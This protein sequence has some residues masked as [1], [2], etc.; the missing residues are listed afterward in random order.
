MVDM[1][2]GFACSRFIGTT[3][4]GGNN[5][6]VTLKYSNMKCWH[7]KKRNTGSH[8]AVHRVRRRDLISYGKRSTHFWDNVAKQGWQ[9][10]T[11]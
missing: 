6:R 8:L 2:A 11:S 4:H 10:A 9:P 1:N 7:P 3:D 5:V